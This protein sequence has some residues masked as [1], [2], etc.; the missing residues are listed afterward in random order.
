MRRALIAA[1]LVSAVGGCS[2]SLGT[3]MPVGGSSGRI[4][5]AGG[6]GT[7]E[8]GSGGVI[9]VGVAGTVGGPAGAGSIAGSG[10]AFGRG[11]AGPTGRGGTGG[12]GRGGSPG[13]GC[14]Q[15]ALPL[16]C[17]AALCG[18][19]SRDSCLVP[20]GLGFCPQVQVS[21]A[22]DGRDL[23][24]STCATEGFGSGTLACAPNCTIDTTGCNECMPLHSMLQRC[25]G[26]PVTGDPVTLSLAATEAEVALAFIDRDADGPPALRLA[27]FS[28]NLDLVGASYI[29]DPVLAAY[30]RG[31][32][33]RTVSVSVAPLPSGWAIAGFAEEELFLHALDTTGTSVA[34]TTVATAPYAHPRLASRPGGGLLL[35]W[36]TYD[37][38]W[39]AVVAADGRS[40]TE[41]L[42]LPINESIVG[43]VRATFAAGAFHIVVPVETAANPSQARVFRI[44]ADGTLAAAFDVLQGA[45]AWNASLVA[46]AEDLRLVY[47]T[48]LANTWV[49][50]WQP[51]DAAGNERGFPVVIASGDDFTG[52]VQAFGFGTDSAALLAGTDATTIGMV[53]FT[54]QGTIVTPPYKIASS[55]TQFLDWP[56]AAR[57]GTDIVAAWTGSTQPRIRMARVTP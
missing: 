27:R 25:G 1:A 24:T 49:F 18:T 35:W 46:G 33:P 12:G 23:G 32:V 54:G 21:E 9:S 17:P 52:Q 2:G 55:R 31:S 29:A 56:A 47:Q 36:Q 40:V 53:R 26:V 28:P 4:V 48:L 19:G 20:S 34:R 38:T 30:P 11:G 41:P 7:G 57:R 50:V 15:T 39:V 37:A 43:E 42:A 10:G 6:A 16:A 13:E 45:A 8:A 5:G 22:C 3:E 14:L 51:L 44:A